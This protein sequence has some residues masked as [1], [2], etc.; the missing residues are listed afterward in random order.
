MPCFLHGIYIGGN[1]ARIVPI[2]SSSTTGNSVYFG[3]AEQG[4]LIDMGCSFKALKTGLELNGLSLDCVKAVCVTHE[5]SDHIKGLKMLTKHTNIPIYATNGTLIAIV[6]QQAV[7]STANLH[8]VSELSSAPIDMEIESFAT[9]HDSAESCGYT[10][11]LEGRKLALCTDLGNVTDTVRESLKGSDYVL[12]EANYD[13][14]MLRL[15]PKYPYYLK[16]RIS[17]GYGHLSNVKTAQFMKELVEQGTR[18]IT[19]GHLSLNNNTPQ[20]AKETIT[21]SLE[22][23]GIRENCDYVLDVAEPLNSGKYIA[24]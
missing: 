19:L 5:H 21:K 6:N 2:C 3:S 7:V 24:I 9:P 15:N 23:C 18:H 11:K 20:R 4:V 8:E 22:Q 14:E 1:M 12:L 16:K 10:M 17:S 13:E